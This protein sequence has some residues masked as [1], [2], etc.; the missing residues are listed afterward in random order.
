MHSS[1]SVSYLVYF[2]K[3]K[4]DGDEDL[5]DIHRHKKSKVIHKQEALAILMILF[6]VQS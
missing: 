6:C 4:H 5:N 3:R 1:A 2:Q